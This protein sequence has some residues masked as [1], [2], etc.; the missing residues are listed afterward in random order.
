M[1]NL[2]VVKSDNLKKVTSNAT[3]SLLKELYDLSLKEDSDD[4]S[5]KE[6]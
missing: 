6:N 2:D 3:E 1:I 4:K 5:A